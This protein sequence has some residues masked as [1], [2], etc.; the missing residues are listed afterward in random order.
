MAC[1]RARPLLD[2][3]VTMM[4]HRL[5]GPALAVGLAMLVATGCSEDT[6]VVTSTSVLI[7]NQSSFTIVEVHLVPVGSPTFGINLLDGNVLLPGE[8]LLLGVGCGFFDALIVD[9]QGVDCEL[10]DLDLCLNN[11]TFVIT[12]STCTVFGARQQA[13]DTAAA[14][15][16]SSRLRQ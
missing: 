6:V 15:A 7:D 13:P 3:W 12:N 11:A 8:S 16:S 4:N 9:E 5:L 2:A 14:P 1:P 10:N